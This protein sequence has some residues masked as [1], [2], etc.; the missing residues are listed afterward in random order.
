MLEADEVQRAIGGQIFI[1]TAPQDGPLTRQAI[2]HLLV[3]ALP[4]A[5][6]LI[7]TLGAS[8]NMVT[9]F[10]CRKEPQ[11]VTGRAGLRLSPRGWQMVWLI[12]VGKYPN[13][14]ILAMASTGG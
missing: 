11:E 6:V 13:P 12:S 2:M 4:Q 14:P 8:T 10:R 9:M 7:G 5:L 3:G 1:P